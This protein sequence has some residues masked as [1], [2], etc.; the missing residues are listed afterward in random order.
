MAPDTA[1]PRAKS[2][3]TPDHGQGRYCSL[4]LAI[5]TTLT[6]L[7][8]VDRQLLVL[9]APQIQGDLAI[10]D[11]GMGLLLG[12]AF[13]LLYGFAALPAGMLA[14]RHSR[15][16]IM[17]GGLLFWS[18]ATIACGLSRNYQQLFLARMAV[19][20]G[21][22]CLGPAAVS[23][24]ADY[25]PPARRGKALAM[26]Q[27]GSIIGGGIALIGGGGLLGLLHDATHITLFG[28]DVASWKMI[29]LIMGTAGIAFAPAVLLVREPAR[30]QAIQ[31]D[32][33]VPSNADV[34]GFWRKN[35]RLVICA[36]AIFA[37]CAFVGFGVT[38]WLPSLIVRE[39]DLP[40][41]RSGLLVGGIT[42]VGGIAGALS[43]GY[44][45]DRLNSGSSQGRRFDGVLVAWAGLL[46]AVVGLC[47]PLALPALLAVIALFSFANT[48]IV[49]MAPAVLA[50]IFPAQLRATAMAIY[51][52]NLAVFGIALGP[53]TGALINDALFDGG[54][55]RLSLGAIAVPTSLVAILIGVLVR[56]KF[57]QHVKGA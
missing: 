41:S 11:T 32:K 6:V 9:L 7:S 43:G 12:V 18:C 54:D 44:L 22:A 37:C 53:L 15:R 38:S 35:A 29:F 13:A 19:G 26:F 52:F 40:L 2:A 57:G 28:H 45:G 20:I 48:M 39:Y 17:L 25:F 3:G 49:A 16:N 36:Y 14:D 24:L 33:A 23:L 42:V 21:E 5:V 47:L 4:V 55:L 1:V 50:D 51:F 34:T 31:G 27:M 56:R 10:G 8:Y 30:A 46:A